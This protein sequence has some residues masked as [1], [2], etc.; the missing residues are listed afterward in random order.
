MTNLPD[1]PIPTNTDVRD[2]DGFMLNVERL[3]ASEL[4]ALSSHEEIAAALFLWCRAWK[5]MPAASL[6][7]DEQVIAAFAKL[8]LQR[9]RKLRAKVMRGFVKCSD[10]RWYHS[11]L[12]AEAFSAFMRKRS[13][14]KKREGDAERLRK[15]RESKRE[16]PPE[17][18][19][20][21]PNETRFVAEGQGQ[22]Q[23][24]GQGHVNPVYT[25]AS[26]DS[27]I[28]SPGGAASARM[29]KAGL[30][31]ANPSHPK[32]LALLD[33]GITLDELG[34]AAEE[35][36]KKKKGFAYAL[37][38]AEGRR[39]DS[40]IT[41]LP[42]ASPGGGKHGLRADYLR[43]QGYTGGEDGNSSGERIIDGQAERVA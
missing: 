32:L 42:R 16:T 22:G 18:P 9:F 11:V 39:R 34:Q 36:V 37:A 29:R 13:F 1:P 5:Q 24:Q 10:G 17:T 20:E 31:D 27:T 23:G 4:V 41:P 14:H 25:H 28:P 40:A 21:T 33:Q 3:M 30:Q 8:P 38:V 12:A 43:Q 2:L 19:N 26:T 6:P 35:A 15:W 7:D